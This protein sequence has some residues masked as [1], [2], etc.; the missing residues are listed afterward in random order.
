MSC[1]RGEPRELLISKHADGLTQ[2]TCYPADTLPKDFHTVTPLC[3]AWK[4]AAGN[5]VEPPSPLRPIK[6]LFTP[7]PPPD[8]TGPWPW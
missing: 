4:D 6:R 8:H 5:V 7:A 3:E 2:E 1:D